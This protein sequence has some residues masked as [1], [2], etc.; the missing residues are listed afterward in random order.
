[1][2]I[3][4]SLFIFNLRNRC[5]AILRF[6]SAP[7]GHFV[8]TALCPRTP[9]A[10]LKVFFAIQL[11][12]RTFRDSPTQSNYVNNLKGGLRREP[13]VPSWGCEGHF[14]V[15]LVPSW[16]C[17]GGCVPPRQQPLK[18]VTPSHAIFIVCA[19]FFF[20]HL[21]VIP[22]YKV[23]QFVLLFSFTY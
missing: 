13:L 3:Q 1:M 22:G 5:V 12:R 18:F 20:A 15:P 9:T 11:F 19:Q 21:S 16:G 6:Y 17:E 23:L 14:V 10:T 2:Y 4:S 8:F 7:L